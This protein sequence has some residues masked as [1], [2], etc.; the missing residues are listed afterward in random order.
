MVYLQ[1]D[2]RKNSVNVEKE[3]SKLLLWAV[4]A[5]TGA[6]WEAAQNTPQKSLPRD[7]RTG[8]SIHQLL[9]LVVEGCSWTLSL[10]APLEA[11]HRPSILFL[12]DNAF[13]RK[14]LEASGVFWNF[15]Q[16]LPSGPAMLVYCTF[17]WGPCDIEPRCQ[18]ESPN[19]S[20][21]L[22]S[23]TSPQPPHNCWVMILNVT[24]GCD[25]VLLRMESFNNSPRTRGNTSNSPTWLLPSFLY[26][27]L[28][29]YPTWGPFIPQY[30]T[31]S[32]KNSPFL[33][34]SLLDL[35][36][37]WPHPSAHLVAMLLSSKPQ[38]RNHLYEVFP[39]FR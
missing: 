39:C 15:I 14:S 12:P 33:C 27:L 6:L 31:F 28:P 19:V 21:Y 13:R 26:L 16:W 3:D 8:I 2:P 37:P 9:S 17:M 32:T 35:L 22:P 38:I 5:P 11:E 29:L 23:H 25:H 20:P 7:E 34:S 4:G 1:D 24:Y 30:L 10:L 18:Q 36:L